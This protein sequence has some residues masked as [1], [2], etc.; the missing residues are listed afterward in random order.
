MNSSGIN[1]L[2]VNH[3]ENEVTI[4]YLSQHPPLPRIHLEEWG[5]IHPLIWN[6]SG[7]NVLTVNH[8]ENEVTIPYLSQHPPL[9]RITRSS[10]VISLSE[11][12]INIRTKWRSLEL[13]SV[14]SG[15][16]TLMNSPGIN[17]RKY[18]IRKYAGRKSLGK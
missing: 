7:I 6:S 13:I 4:P 3:M 5:V 15:D 14:Q 17:I 16:N 2:T 10:R 8:M 12:G 11:P 9:P 1:V 18:A